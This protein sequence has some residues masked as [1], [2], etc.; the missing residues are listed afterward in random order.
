MCQLQDRSRLQRNKAT[1][2]FFDE[3]FKNLNNS[4][5]NFN[6]IFRVTVGLRESNQDAY[7]P[8]L[9]SIGPY[10]IKNLEFRSMENY[11][12]RYLQRFLQRKE[13]IDLVSC[14]NELEELKDDA[15]K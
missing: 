13:G 4:S 11:K 2:Q 5:I 14:I 3:K 10:H 6:A 9:I 1:K 15:L 12:L 7:K 8:K